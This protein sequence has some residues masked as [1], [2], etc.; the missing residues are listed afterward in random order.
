[1]EAA[2]VHV[3]GEATTLRRR[4]FDRQYAGKERKGGV[5]VPDGDP[6]VL[7][8]EVDRCVRHRPAI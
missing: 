6:E 4:E 1:M 2:P 7:K 8:P 3:L 5:D